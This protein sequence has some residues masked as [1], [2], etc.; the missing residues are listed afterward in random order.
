MRV[1][2]VC[3][4]GVLSALGGR[5]AATE[6]NE[7][8]QYV[9]TERN[10]S[11]RRASKGSQEQQ[12][13]AEQQSSAEQQ[14]TYYM[15]AA[16]NAMDAK[17]YDDALALSEFAHMIKPDDPAVNYFLGVLYEG[18]NRKDDALRAYKKAYEGSPDDYWQAYFHIVSSRSDGTRRQLERILKAQLK[19]RPNDTEVLSAMQSVA[20]NDYDVKTALR[21]QDDID[22]IEGKTPQNVLRRYQLLRIADKPDK[23]IA[24]IDDYC[25]EEPD[26][27]YFQVFR[28]DH[29]FGQNDKER[30]LDIYMQVLHDSPENPYVYQSLARYY[31]SEND[32]QSARQMLGKLIDISSSEELLEQYFDLL[33]KDS[34]VSDDEQVA[35]VQKA[36]LMEPNSAKWHYYWSLALV[37]QDSVATAIEVLREGIRLG[38]KDAVTRFS[39][40]VLSGDLFMRQGQLDSCF[41]H[42]E[43]AL[44]LDPENV[45][46]L[47]NYAYTLAVNG[48]DL[49]K[50]EKMSQKTI[51]KEPNN[52]TYLDTYAWILHLQGQDSLAKFYMKRAMEKAGEMSE[53]NELKSHYDI[54]FNTDNEQD[55]KP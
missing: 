39:M 21:L 38:E 8:M 14:F 55:E 53:D 18:T 42:Y 26:D 3:V 15:Y 54:L 16:Q 43:K 10:R 34:T 4:V 9:A 50:A 30:A 20:L 13:P 51:E 24:V 33:V 11:V 37:Q 2:I 31:K 32:E 12:M 46:V 23:A 1:I 44:I 40:H 47:N 5:C 45:Y 25:R 52:A 22:R 17:R 48:G 29:Y 35:F 41:A 27:E 49:K 7:S 6:R 19:R 28:G 36:Y